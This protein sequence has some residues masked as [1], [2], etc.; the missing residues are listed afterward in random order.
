MRVQL[1]EHTCI[2][3][4]E[5]GDPKFYGVRNAAGESQLLHAVK[6]A[7]SQQGYDFIKKRMWKDG[8]LVDDLQQYLRERKPVRGRML[9]ISNPHW[10][11]RGAEVDFNEGQVALAV[12]DL[13]CPS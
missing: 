8:H 13:G 5:A 7:L 6:H 10:A 4:R 9:A 12:D 11:I 1:G 2:V 3:T